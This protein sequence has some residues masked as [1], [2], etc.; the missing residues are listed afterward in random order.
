M[1]VS[2][3]GV[4]NTVLVPFV[5]VEEPW[6]AALEI[7]RQAN[8]TAIRFADGRVLTTAGHELG[9]GT[10]QQFFDLTTA[11]RAAAR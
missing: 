5:S 2:P 8:G 4:R 1:L 7:S 6:R 11:W 9:G 3:A 10:Q